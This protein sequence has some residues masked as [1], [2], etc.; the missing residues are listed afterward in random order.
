[1]F[2][3]I[4]VQESKGITQTRGSDRPTGYPIEYTFPRESLF[5]A[6]PTTFLGASRHID[7]SHLGVLHE[8]LSP[9]K[10]FF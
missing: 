1:M 10:R 8:I 6:G 4:Q 2:F 5:M 3:V 9:T 7:R